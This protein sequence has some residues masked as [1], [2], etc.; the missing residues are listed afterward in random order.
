MVFCSAEMKV[1]IITSLFTEWDMNIYS[2]HLF[3]WL[4]QILEKSVYDFDTILVSVLI[5]TFVFTYYKTNYPFFFKKYFHLKYILY[6][7][8]EEDYFYRSSLLSSAHIIPIIIYSLI[9][10]FF[11]VYIFAKD[12]IS[13]FLIEFEFSLFVVWIISFF[14]YLFYIPLRILIIKLFFLF[15][16]E[17]EKFKIIFLINFIRITIFFSLINI[18]FSYL[19]YALFSFDIAYSFFIFLGLFIILVRPILLFYNTKK[20]YTS[21]NTKFIGFILFADLFPIL[22]FLYVSYYFDLSKEI[23]SIIGA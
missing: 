23:I 11:Y 22:F 17:A 9:I 7:S 20:F 8:Y 4:L 15:I 10:S 2:C 1:T 21:G 12:A 14:I 16:N 5:I 19:F 6:S 13:T 3:I 18:F